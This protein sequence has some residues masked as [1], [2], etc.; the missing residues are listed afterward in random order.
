MVVPNLFRY[1]VFFVFCTSSLLAQ[2]K[3][4]KIWATATFN[5]TEVQLGEPLVVTV[6]VYTS[7]WF[8]E[9]PIFEEIQVKGSL[10]AKL[11]QRNSATSVNIGRKQY[12]A[13]KQRFVIYPNVIGKNTLPSFKVITNCP[14]EGDYKGIKREVY[15]KETT[16]TVLSPPEDVDPKTYLASYKVTLKDQWDTNFKNLKAGDVLERRITISASGALAAAIPPIQIDSIEFGSTYIKS[17]ILVNRQNRN[18]FSGVRTE[19]INYLLEKDGEFSIPPIQMNWFNL[20]TKAKDSSSLNSVALTVADNPDLSFILSRQKELQQE[21]AESQEEVE[22][23]K[24]SFE[25]FGL[26]WWQ[27]LL[28]LLFFLAVLRFLT[29][30]VK[31]FNLNRRDIKHKHL[32]SE[33]YYFQ[34]L[35]N[36]LRNGSNQEIIKNIY[37]WFD[38]YRGQELGP[39]V[40]ELLERLNDPDLSELLN[41]DIAHQYSTNTTVKLDSIKKLVKAVE[42]SRLQDSKRRTKSRTQNLKPINP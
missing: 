31:K 23:N 35:K 29:R 16:F 12:P 41:K 36:S 11:E 19:I 21:L 34:I 7:T 4:A 33:S 39:Q 8:T 1:I 9:P 6:T 2:T 25:L 18:S 15:S 10:M 3:P 32:E 13:I 17:P 27:L 20:R 38:R 24:L 28:I 40:S 5:K 14:P 42:S 37:A 30:W 26:N 22:E